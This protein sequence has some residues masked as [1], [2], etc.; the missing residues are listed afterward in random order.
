MTYG[1]KDYPGLLMSVTGYGMEVYMS[2]SD[3]DGYISF[4]TIVTIL[5]RVGSSFD[6]FDNDY[7]SLSYTDDTEIEIDLIENYVSIQNNSSKETGGSKDPTKF[8]N[9]LS[10]ILNK[11]ETLKNS[12]IVVDHEPL[13]ISPEVILGFLN[14]TKKI[15]REKVINRILNKF[16]DDIKYYPSFG[17]SVYISNEYAL[18]LRDDGYIEF[19]WDPREAIRTSDSITKSDLKKII[20]DIFS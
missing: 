10:L 18:T 20:Y 12:E 9:D 4:D 17:E 5:S 3:I 19:N 14:R 7:R 8:N 16:N 13:L 11:F 2:P 15:T 6:Y 1:V